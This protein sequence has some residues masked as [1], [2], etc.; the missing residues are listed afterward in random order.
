VIIGFSLSTKRNIKNFERNTS[1]L[2]ERLSAAKRGTEM[3]FGIAFHFDP[4]IWYPEWEKDYREV[5][6]MVFESLPVP[7]S[8]A[9][10]S[11]G[12]LRCMPSLKRHLE[13]NRMFHNLFSGEMITGEDGKTRYFRP[14][15][16]DF[17]SAVQEQV[18][19]HFPATPLYLCM[20]SREVWKESGMLYRIPDGLPAY[21]DSQALRMLKR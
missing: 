18:S 12:G 4:M 16:V 2:R 13:A 1:S 8:I 5:V 14:I 9:W 10:W 19:K 17:Y 21:L 20:E 6:D 7:S 3:G 11:M 15:R